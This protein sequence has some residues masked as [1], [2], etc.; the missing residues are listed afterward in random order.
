MTKVHDD[1]ARRLVSLEPRV[2]AAAVVQRVLARE[3]IQPRAQRSRPLRTAL[4]TTVFLIAT[5]AVSSYYAPVF[6]Q[7]VADAPIAGSITGWMLRNA[8]LAGVPHRVTAIGDVSR[9]AGFDVELVGA[10]ADPGRTILFLRASPAARVIPSVG[11]GPEFVLS[12]QFGQ[13][14]RSTFAVQNMLTGENMFAFEP[15]RWPATVVGARLHLAFNTV[16]VGLAPNSTLATGRWGLN[17]TLAIEESR[18]LSRPVGG[19]IGQMSIA[20]A[21]IQATQS[22]LFLDLDL[23]PG[24][25]DLDRMIADG[26]KGHLAFA[27]RLYDSAGREQLMLQSS[28][29]SSGRRSWIWMLDAPGRYELRIA[30]E[31]VGSLTRQLEV[32]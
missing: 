30:Y 8:G 15:L 23:N 24:G 29:S 25:L 1:L 20:F 27:V 22:A 13:T 11:I 7:A 9:S 18:E 3:R 6:A 32:P 21:R 12:D 28:G 17:A 14:Y 26:L 10:Y 2:D 5:I 31:G 19:S 16:E 4:A